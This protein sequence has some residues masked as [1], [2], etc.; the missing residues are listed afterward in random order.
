MEILDTPTLPYQNRFCSN[1]VVHA[2]SVSRS[3]EHRTAEWTVRWGGVELISR[4]VGT[5]RIATQMIHLLLDGGKG[6][7]PSARF[8]YRR[9]EPVG[10]RGGPR[11][12][13]CGIKVHGSEPVFR[14]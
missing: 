4:D 5:E 3:N 13:E 10:M 7:Y 12:S 14:V 11:V 8:F 2:V 6:P 9:L 1:E